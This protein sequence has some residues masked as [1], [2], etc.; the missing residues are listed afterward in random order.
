[1]VVSDL[2]RQ[3]FFLALCLAKMEV[4]EGIWK[5]KGRRREGLGKGDKCTGISR[6]C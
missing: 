3:M 5:L 6:V 4:T 1:M 2:S